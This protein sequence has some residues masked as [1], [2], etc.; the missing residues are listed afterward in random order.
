DLG[1][2]WELTDGRKGIVQALGDNF[3]SLNRVPHIQLDGDDR[4][5][6]VENGENLTIN[7]DQRAK[8]KRILIF[9][10]LYEG[11]QSFAGLHAVVTL[12]P[13]HGAPIEMFLDE[14]TVPARIVALALIQNIN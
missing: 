12:Y 8:F 3:G 14:C 1:C 4:T 6:A 11:A 13:E 5:G 10:D 2:L 7:L 9:V